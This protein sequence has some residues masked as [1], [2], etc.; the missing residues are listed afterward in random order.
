M[1]YSYSLFVFD[2]LLFN[3]YTVKPHQFKVLGPKNQTLD[4]MI[5]YKPI[6]FNKSWSVVRLV[7]T[8]T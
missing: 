7:K 8:M 1:L 4:Y 3:L 5:S 6:F 2:V